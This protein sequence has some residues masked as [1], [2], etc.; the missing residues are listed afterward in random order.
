M[1]NVP[2]DVGT[3]SG[4]AQI[5]S[6]ISGSFNKGFEFVGSISGSAN[7]TGSFS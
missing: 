5:K 6:Q 7:S 1:T 2:I 4:S 3:L